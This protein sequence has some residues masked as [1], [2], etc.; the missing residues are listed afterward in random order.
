MGCNES[1]M[2]D[3][4]N[5]VS[6]VTV[7]LNGKD[8]SVRLLLV[9]GPQE[10]DSEDKDSF[11]H[12]VSVQVEMVYLIGD[13]VIMVE[14]FNAILGY[15]VIST[16][17][18][19]MSKNG[20]Q[21]FELCNKYNLKPINASEHCEGVFTRIHKYMQTIEKSVLDYVF[22]S[23]DLEEYFTSKQID[24]EKHFTPWRSLKHGKRY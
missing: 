10:N 21:L 22:I 1:V 7:C 18:Y 13:S 17:L 5:K 8:Y 16:D 14:D 20:E 12:D 23:S 11:Y 3:S 15:D 2:I 24:E 19:H 9:Y 4:G 6:F